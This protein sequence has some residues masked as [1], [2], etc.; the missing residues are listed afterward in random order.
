MKYYFIQNI[1][2]PYRVSLFNNL[3]SLGMDFEVLY[4]SAKE[5]DR[6][7]AIDIDSLKYPY[8]VYSGVYR[9]LNGFHLHFNPTMIKKCLALRNAIIILGGSWNDLNVVSICLLKRLGLIRSDLCF[10]AEANYLTI[11]ASKKNAFRDM[12][13]NFIY[14][15]GN[16]TYIVPGRMSVETLY[17]WRV[18]VNHV[19]YL[20][21][22]IDES[23]FGKSIKEYTQSKSN[24]IPKFVIPARLIEKYKGILNFFKK[25]GRENVLKCKFYVLGN[26]PDERL[27]S[28]Y[29]EE[30]GYQENIFL[31]GFKT[32]KEVF[33]YYVHSDAMILPSF[34]DPSPLSLPEGLSVGLPLLVSNRC[35]NYF[36]S[37]ENDVNGY[38]FDPFDEKSVNN[39]FERFLNERQRWQSMGEESLRLFNKN[40][41]QSVVLKKFVSH[42]KDA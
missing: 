34:S 2:A 15:C 5:S 9:S 11:G 8:H 21:N 17:K 33:L 27:Y 39:A 20:P 1:I 4:M 10:W 32:S 18:S 36:E 30:N 24:D 26:G 14:S 19:I 25:I 42:L 6:S 35:G 31:E 3:K 16:G 22:V 28:S 41:K 29:I 37:L 12:L 13:R 23:V 40:F 38:L 7:W